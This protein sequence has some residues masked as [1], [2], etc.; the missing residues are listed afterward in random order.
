[1]KSGEEVPG[2]FVVAGGNSPEVL[3]PAKAAFDDIAPFIGL[4]VEAVESDAIGL[5]GNDGLGAALGNLR[6]QVIAIIALV[7]KQS[8]HVR[9]ERQNIGSGSDVGIL[10]RCQ[11]Q[12]DRSAKRIAQRV[13][14]GR[15]P[16]AGTADRLIAF[17][18]FPPEAQ[19]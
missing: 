2:E 16:A 7:C 19:R 6:A 9:R 8:V 13:D 17:P 5:V 15:A 3:E 4:F 12:N 18:P 11:M 10:A 1:M 14:F